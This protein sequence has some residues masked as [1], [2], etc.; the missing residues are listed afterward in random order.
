MVTRPQSIRATQP[1]SG[2]MD[3]IHNHERVMISYKMACNRQDH[4]SGLGKDEIRPSDDQT[5]PRYGDEPLITCSLL[6]KH[7]SWG[8]CNFEI[9]ERRVTVS[10]ST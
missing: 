1:G 6:Y 3:Q 4:V 9:F 10:L 5:S 7:K 2:P 8:I